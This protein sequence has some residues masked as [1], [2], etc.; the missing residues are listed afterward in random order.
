MKEKTTLALSHYVRSLFANEWITESMDKHSI[1]IVLCGRI[2]IIKMSCS[3]VMYT[4]STNELN[5]ALK[6]ET[7]RKE[8]DYDHFD[9][10]NRSKYILGCH[11]YMLVPRRGAA[12][13][14]TGLSKELVKLKNKIKLHGFVMNYTA[15]RALD[16]LSNDHDI[17]VVHRLRC[18]RQYYKKYKFSQVYPRKLQTHSIVQRHLAMDVSKLSMTSVKHGIVITL[19]TL[20]QYIAHSSRASS[21]YGCSGRVGSDNVCFLVFCPM[22]GTLSTAKVVMNQENT[23]GGGTSSSTSD[24]LDIFLVFDHE[25]TIRES[26]KMGTQFQTNAR[27]SSSAMAGSSG[28]HRTPRRDQ[29]RDQTPQ[30]T[31]ALAAKPWETTRM[32]LQRNLSVAAAHMLRD[33]LW[34]L[35]RTKGLNQEQYDHLQR[36]VLKT[37]VHD[38]DENLLEL[39]KDDI[40]FDLKN[41]KRDFLNYIHGFYSSSA[42]ATTETSAATVTL[43]ENERLVSL[44]QYQCG[45]DR[46]LIAN[47]DQALD[48]MFIENKLNVVLWRRSI[49]ASVGSSGLAL[50]RSFVLQYGSW[51]WEDCNK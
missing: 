51:C 29:R 47:A 41:D 46:L 39:L 16:A 32:W 6:D 49:G 43:T 19:S 36:Y 42:T 28:N 31:S 2:V 27:K 15:A 13:L 26:T 23:R 17:H 7:K 10:K 8:D 35:A 18:F 30:S 9:E 4:S 37:S 38:I 3:Q 50:I 14:S 11:I 20:I 12:S 24:G 22:Q 5:G 33:G 45:G 25:Q 40:D 44:V 34:S 48:I 1:G 21:V